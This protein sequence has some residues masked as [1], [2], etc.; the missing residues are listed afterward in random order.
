MLPVRCYTCN[1]IIGHLEKP[2][3]EFK[4]QEPK[5]LEPFFIKHRLERYCCRRILLTFVPNCNDTEMITRTLPETVVLL[6]PS[7]IIPR[8][9]LA[10]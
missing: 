4:K 6:T 3:M 7:R 8:I 5:T 1:K 2:L 9:F 10:R